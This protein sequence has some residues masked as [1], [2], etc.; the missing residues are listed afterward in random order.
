[1]APFDLGM[2]LQLRPNR[3]KGAKGASFLPIPPRPAPPCRGRSG[4]GTF[5]KFGHLAPFGNVKRIPQVLTAGAV[6]D[7]VANQVAKS[8]RK[9]GH[10]PA[11]L[12]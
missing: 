3:I 9:L 11:R 5:G 1:L 12:Q 8:A 4:R 6:P 7:Q 2:P 10:G